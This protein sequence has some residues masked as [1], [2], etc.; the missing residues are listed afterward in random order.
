VKHFIL[1]YN[2]EMLALLKKI[3]SDCFEMSFGGGER[4]WVRSFGIG[5]PLNE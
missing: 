5:E 4:M 2:W 1:I 3:H